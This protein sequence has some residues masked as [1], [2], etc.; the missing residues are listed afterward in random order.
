MTLK[1]IRVQRRGKAGPSA[2]GTVDLYFDA[3]IR[4]WRYVDEDGNTY[5]LASGG[6]GVTSHPA[7]TSLGWTASGHT[8]S[9]TYRLAGSGASTA[10]AEITYTSYTATLL[11]DADAATAR[12]TLGLVIGTDVQAYD[13]GLTSLTAAD[14][15]A[16]LPYVSAANT[17]ASA[18]YSGMLSVVSGAWKVVGLRESGGTDLT[19]GAI[20]GSKLLGV[21][22]GSVGGVTVGTGLSLSAGTLAVDTSTIATQAWVGAGYQPLDSDLTA[23]AALSSTGLVARTGSGTAA[24]RTITGGS[25]VTV[26][27]GS[28]VSG[29]PTISFAGG[30]GQDDDPTTA[31]TI[32]VTPSNASLFSRD[33]G[34]TARSTANGDT[35]Q[36]RATQL[37]GSISDFYSTVGVAQT[38]WNYTGYISFKVKLITGSSIAAT[39]RYKMGWTNGGLSSLD[40]ETAGRPTM[41]F[42]YLTGLSHT[43]WMCYTQNAAGSEE[44]DSLVAVAINTVY[45]LEVRLTSTSITYLINGNTVAT[46]TTRIP[47]TTAS[48]NFQ[49]GNYAT[50]RS[51]YIIGSRMT[52][53][54]A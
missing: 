27:N 22:S 35:S 34:V 10:A 44:T 1:A 52:M 39:S 29:N 14:A 24:A 4:S 30:T 54:W 26:T 47:P 11:D 18:T 12:A 38:G 50:S 53:I 42:R 28:G 25:G 7:L 33:S 2:P 41:I 3:T 6:G 49:C 8:L 45:M 31:Y 17:W 15:S 5:A 36:Y 32:S 46:H 9:T 23:I 16:G 37:T 19:I 43:N 21:A 13:A 51:L 20:S 40:A 48:L